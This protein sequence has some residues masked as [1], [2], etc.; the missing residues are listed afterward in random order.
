MSKALNNYSR[1][2][3]LEMIAEQQAAELGTWARVLL[4]CRVRELLVELGGMA[5]EW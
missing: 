2:I 5:G 3:M 1:K 4:W